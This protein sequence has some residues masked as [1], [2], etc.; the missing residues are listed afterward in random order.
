MKI[1]LWRAGS[2]RNRRHSWGNDNR[3]LGITFDDGY[4]TVLANAVPELRRH[5]F[6]A[7]VF[8]VSDHGFIAVTKTL[9]PN[10]ILREEGVAPLKLGGRPCPGSA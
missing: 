3:R 7:T 1:A 2:T 6:T 4:T 9:R 5:G 10:A 8:V